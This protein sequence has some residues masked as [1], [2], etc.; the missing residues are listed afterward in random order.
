MVFFRS[1]FGA[2]V[3]PNTQ[4]EDASGSLY[5]EGMRLRENPGTVVYPNQSTILQTSTTSGTSTISNNG[6]PVK[7]HPVQHRIVHSVKPTSDNPQTEIQ[8]S[9]AQLRAPSSPILKAQLSAPP[10]TNCPNNPNANQIPQTN[11]IESKSQVG[12]SRCFL[13]QLQE[14]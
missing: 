13:F 1:V 9:A 2:S 14:K 10:K 6:T 4:T 8:I 12:Q 11:V 7:V 3:G 5:Y